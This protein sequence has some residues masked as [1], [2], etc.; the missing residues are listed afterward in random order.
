MDA[1]HMT[2]K[3]QDHTSCESVT[4]AHR[5]RFAWQ[6]TLLFLVSAVV[7]RPE[8]P[9]D[10]TAGTADV[11]YIGNGESG[12]RTAPHLDV[13]DVVVLSTRLLV[14]LRQQR[15]SRLAT[16]QQNSS[17]R[18]APIEARATDC[19]PVGTT[20]LSKALAQAALSEAGCSRCIGSLGR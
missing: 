10:H 1:T 16:L 9:L 14:Q 4:A 8:L 20:H 6:T 5:R 12:G 11:A 17:V 3:A 19:A 7:A 15:R 18:E 13:P 2:T